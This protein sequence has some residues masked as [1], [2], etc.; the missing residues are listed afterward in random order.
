VDDGHT[1]SFLERFYS[2]LKASKG[3]ADALLQTQR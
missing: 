3:R 1:R 2:L